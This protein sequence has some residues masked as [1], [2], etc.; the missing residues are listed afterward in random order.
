[1][2]VAMMA[3]SVMAAPVTP[4]RSAAPTARL[5][6]GPGRSTIRFFLRGGAKE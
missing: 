1:M 3:A 6:P 2:A 5:R 4:P